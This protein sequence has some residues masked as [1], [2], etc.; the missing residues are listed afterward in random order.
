M[1]GPISIDLIE[2]PNPTALDD[3]SKVKV[4]E[5]A[6]SIKENSLSHPIIVRP[7]NIS[8]RYI[9]VSG[10][11]RVLACKILG[12]AEIEADIRDISE[13]ASKIVRV[14]ENLR[15]FNLPWYEQVILVE[16]LHALR[17]QEHGS[18]IIRAE[19]VGRPKKE[20]G[21]KWGI[22]ETAEELGMA[23]GPLSE[24]LNLARAVR[25]DPSL[26][27]IKDKKTAV[28]LV[29]LA[30]QRHEAELEATMPTEQSYN[31]VFF[32]D[33]AEILSRFKDNSFDHCI[34]DPPWIKFF[35]SS[36]TIDERTLPV[37]KQIYRVLKNDA[38]LLFFCGLDDFHYYCGVDRPDK[39]GTIIHT[40]GELEKIG[41]TVS[42][43]PSIWK[44]ESALSRR[45]VRSWEYDRDFEFVIVA[46][47]G[48]PAMA[49]STVISAFKSFPV[50]PSRSLIHP[51]EKPTALIKAYLDDISYTGNIILDPFGGSG[52]TAQAC[53]ELKRRWVVC[54]RDRESYKKICKRLGIKP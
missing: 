20:E 38:F 31:E 29:R 43:T 24:D 45:G 13:N 6:D 39:S 4:Q 18:S 3:E 16:E 9:L 33:S 35:D 44:K 23:L 15:R 54:E 5:L 11:K 49:Q 36:L 51:N 14:H 26:R 12:R 10:E 50:V 21:K 2:I 37:F 19:A 28:R 40:Q 25:L 42:K 22:R 1:R 34:T 30:K 7:A 8:G 41:F 32:G 46:A 53:R 17:Q 52:V 27:N 47:K 48:S